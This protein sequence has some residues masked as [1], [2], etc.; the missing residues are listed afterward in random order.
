MPLDGQFRDNVIIQVK[1]GPVDFQPREPFSPLFGAMKKTS[2]MPE[3]QITQEYL[4]QAIHLVFLS[5]MWEECFRVI[6]T[7]KAPEAQLP[8]APMEVFILKNIQPL[9]VSLILDWIQTG[10]VMILRKLTGMPLVVWPGMII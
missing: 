2:V 4:G 6:L 5:P 9:Q 1:N 3:F 8:V 7:R 10:A